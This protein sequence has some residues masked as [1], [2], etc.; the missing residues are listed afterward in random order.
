MRLLA[1]VGYRAKRDPPPAVIYF[2]QY[3]RASIQAEN[4]P[5]QTTFRNPLSSKIK[6]QSTK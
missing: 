2:T 1:S 6:V 4:P 3:P 5:H